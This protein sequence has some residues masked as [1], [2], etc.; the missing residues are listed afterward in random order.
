MRSV[1][2]LCGHHSVRAGKKSA[3]ACQPGVGRRGGLPLSEIKIQNSSEFSRKRGTQFTLSMDSRRKTVFWTSTIGRN[4]TAQPSTKSTKATEFCTEGEMTLKAF[5]SRTESTKITFEF[6][7][8]AQLTPR[9]AACMILPESKN[10][11]EEE[12]AACR[13]RFGT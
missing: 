11:F 9:G 2:R 12:R 5:V 6:C 3:V 4:S 13:Y 7:K 8:H 10:V 1:C